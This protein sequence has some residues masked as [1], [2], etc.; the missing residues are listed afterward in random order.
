MLAFRG[1]ENGNESDPGWFVPAFPFY[2]SLFPEGLTKDQWEDLQVFDWLNYMTLTSRIESPVEIALGNDPPDR[3]LIKHK[4][5][6]GLELRQLTLFSIRKE[7]APVRDFGQRLQALLRQRRNEFPHLIGKKAFIALTGSAINRTEFNEQ[8]T[9]SIILALS[10]DLGVFGEDVVF[11]PDGSFPAKWP[12]THR[13]FYG[14]IGP[15]I[16]Q[17]QS[18][19]LADDIQVVCAAQCQVKLSEAISALKNAVSEKDIQGN[20]VLL[21]T[22]GLPD[23]RGFQCPLDYW[24]FRHIADQKARICEFLQPKHI[25]SIIIRAWNGPETF[26]LYRKESRIL[27]WTKF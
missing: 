18:S 16:L 2:M 27:P 17:V 9:D 23:V 6:Y 24:L 25:Q 20:D 11:G 1:I 14:N 7:L 3:L 26:E 21:I 4:Q 19:G 13:G 8:L 22:C 12:E 10:K 15:F 5:S